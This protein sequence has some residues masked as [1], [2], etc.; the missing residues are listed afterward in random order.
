MTNRD[1]GG[2]SRGRGRGGGRGAPGGTRYSN[3]RFSAERSSGP[4]APMRG[5]GGPRGGR[6]G[7]RDG[8]EFRHDGQHSA[9]GRGKV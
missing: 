9:D 7:E 8:G 6:G 2:M 3:E 5:R 4:P 1:R